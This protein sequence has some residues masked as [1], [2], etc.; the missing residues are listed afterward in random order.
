MKVVHFSVVKNTTWSRMITEVCGK[1]LPV[2]SAERVTN[3]NVFIEELHHY[4]EHL[5]GCRQMI[6]TLELRHTMQQVRNFCSL[7]TVVLLYSIE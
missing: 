3:S 1:L 7:F 2:S 5:D 6:L 4:S